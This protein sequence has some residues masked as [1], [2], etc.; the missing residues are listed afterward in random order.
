MYQEV[1]KA[2]EL[3]KE[4]CSRS[5]ENK[6]LVIIDPLRKSALGKKCT[7]V[8]CTLDHKCIYPGRITQGVYYNR[9]QLDNGIGYQ[10]LG[11]KS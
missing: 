5:H 9:H 3:G 4:P 2:E 7:C 8:H 1:C 11:S 10:I 6:Q